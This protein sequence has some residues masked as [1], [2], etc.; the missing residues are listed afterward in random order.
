MLLSSVAQTALV[1]V[2][3]PSKCSRIAHVLDKVKCI[4]TT[5]FFHL[6]GISSYVSSYKF[7]QQLVGMKLLDSSFQLFDTSK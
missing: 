7:S 1:T 2:G 3:T 4:R 5:I 6:G